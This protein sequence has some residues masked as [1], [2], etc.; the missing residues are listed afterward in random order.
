[1]LGEHSWHH[2]PTMI[3]SKWARPSSDAFGETSCRGGDLG[4]LHGIDLMPLVLAHS[5]RLNKYG[6]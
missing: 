5:L 1:L 3:H 2:V 4:V 6:A